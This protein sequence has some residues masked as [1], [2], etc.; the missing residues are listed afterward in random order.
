MLRQFLA[1]SF[2]V[3]A[4]ASSTVMAQE[5]VNYDEHIL[6][7]L[8]AK[9]GSCHDTNTAKGGLVLDNYKSAMA[10]GASGEVIE[11]GS[12][13]DSRLWLLVDHKEQPAMPPKEPKLPAEQL[14]LIRKWIEGG[15]MENKT[16]APKVKTKAKPSMT[17][18]EVKGDKPE[19]PPAMPEGISTEPL[20]LS[21]RGNAVTALAASPWAPLVAVAGHQQVLLYDLTDL[22]LAAVLPYPEGTIH[23]LRFSRNGSLLLAAGGRGGQ[24]G[25]VIVFDVKTGKRVFEIGAEFDSV[26]AADISPNHRQIALGGPKKIVKV[27]STA[28][29][30]LQYEIKKHT[31]W[32]TALEFSPD[33]VLLATGDRS[34]GLAVWEADTGREFYILPAHTTAITGVS[35]RLDANLLASIS[36]D[37]TIKL[38]EMQ[39]GGQVKTWGAHG[40]GAS[41]VQ[42]TRDGRLVSTGRDLVTKLWDQNGAQQKAFPSLA[43]LGLKVTYAEN[44]GY[45]I[46]GDWAGNVR[47]WN[48]ADA[49]EKGLLTTNPKALAVRLEEATAA[50]NAAKVAADQAAAAVAALVKAMADKKA[51]ADTAAKA[52]VDGVAAAAAGAAAQVEAGKV[53]EKAKVDEAALVAAHAALEKSKVD[54]KLPAESEEAKTLDKSIVTAKAALDAGTAARVAAEKAAADAAA[55]AK[56]LADQVPVLKAAMDKAAAEAVPT[57]DQQKALAAAQA[58]AKTAADLLAVKQGAVTKLTA[59]KAIPAPAPPATAAK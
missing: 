35:W 58:A 13:D 42:F 11:A 59:Q 9:C 10:G 7:I 32:I 5:K 17:L 30:E 34:N 46:A 56:T 43:D 55:K 44:P 19:G 31:D 16:S 14:A 20:T 4:V 1:V 29:G 41:S 3:A 50:A 27:Y 40:A 36:E 15:V 18:T 33:G 12:P 57:A 25:R 52:H 6:P 22:T 53:V 8:R 48:A 38:W 23:V 28:D 51:L 21:T 54:K 39:N 47:V 26:L 45:V 49:V 37:T 24:T 2:I